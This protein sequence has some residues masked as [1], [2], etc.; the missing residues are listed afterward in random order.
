MSNAVRTLNYIRQN[1]SRQYQDVVPKATEL[2]IKEIGNILLNDSYQ[3]Q[4]NEFVNT[5]INRIALTKIK[6]QSFSNPLAMFKKGS[7]PYG[8]DIQEI[9]ESPAMAETYEYSNA[10]M[11]KLLTI[12]DPDTNVAYY[13]RNRQ[14]IYTKTIAREGLA[15][16]FVSAEKF[17]EYVSSIT[18]SLYSG[19][20]ID[21]FK[22]TKDLI[23]GAYDNGK[24]I[25]E[26]VSAVTS[27]DTAKALIKKCRSLFLKMQCPSTNYNAFSK[28]TS[29]GKTITTWTNSDRICVI[30]TADVMSAVDVD[31]LAGAFNLD[32]GDFM[33][34]VVV[35]DNFENEEI[36]AVI[37]DESFLQIYD[38]L[39]RF[40][41]FYNARTMSWNEYL[42]AW[43]TYA[44]SPFANAVCLAT[45][46][47]KPATAVALNAS[48]YTIDEDET[49]TV[50]VT[51]TPADA[52]T[53]YDLF[54]SDES[55]F[56]VEVSSDIIITGVKA[57]TATLTVITDNGKTAS[58]TV[59]VE[60]ETTT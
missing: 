54:S 38:N 5:L 49:T 37:C 57:G 1:A 9:Y 56:T 21:E 41:E 53:E 46:Q 10:A 16:A 2:N 18:D 52:T 24:I 22:Y 47:P 42:H 44:I 32:K 35:V 59:T 8:T 30:T 4:L 40:D 25:V 11:A 26:T 39:F 28:F 33:G 14:D 17:D 48:S 7:V 23:D 31:A 15:G 55:I 29:S 36:Q 45:A 27:A 20:Y 19:N 50:T 13:R 51:L 34:R 60:E 58:A 3:P 12:T 43:G 6:N